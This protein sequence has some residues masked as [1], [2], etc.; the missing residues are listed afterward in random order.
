MLMEGGHCAVLS[1]LIFLWVG[2]LCVTFE[3]LVITRCARYDCD[4]AYAG[5]GA[6]H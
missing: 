2:A 5:S 1:H 4:K 6:R 3:F